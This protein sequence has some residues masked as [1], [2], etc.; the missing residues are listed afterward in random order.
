MNGHAYPWIE[1]VLTVG[2]WDVVDAAYPD[3]RFEGGLL[4]PAGV[5]R[6]IVASANWIRLRL[7]DGNVVQARSWSGT[8]ELEGRSMA[9]EVAALGYRYLP[10][11]EILDQLEICFQFG[12]S[13]RLRFAD[14]AD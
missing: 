13:V 5:G 7:A 3:T 1:F 8:L 6:E 11:R 4:V 9:V 2:T 10:G 14:E 12:R